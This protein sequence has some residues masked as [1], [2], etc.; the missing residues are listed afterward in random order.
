MTAIARDPNRLRTNGGFTLIELLIVVALIGVLAAIAVISMTR[1]RQS[2]NEASALGSMR[3]I[4]GAPGRLRLD[5]RRRR[6]RSEQRG[7]GEGAGWIAAV[8]SARFGKG[9]SGVEREERLYGGCQRQC[10][11]G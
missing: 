5:L 8:H 2:G 3:A 10:R 6:V 7:S 4:I 9:R 1:A 11:S